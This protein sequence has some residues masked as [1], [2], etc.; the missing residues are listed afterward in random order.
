M[1]SSRMGHHASDEDCRPLAEQHGLRLSPAQAGIKP[2]P[3]TGRKPFFWQSSEYLGE[4][5]EEQENPQDP[6]GS[7]RRGPHVHKRF[8]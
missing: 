3:P 6:A 5:E 4:G 2:Q 7:Q 8:P 1:S